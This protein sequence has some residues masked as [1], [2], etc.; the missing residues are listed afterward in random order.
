MDDRSERLCRGKLKREHVHVHL[1]GRREFYSRFGRG[2]VS[3]P[4]AVGETISRF[5]HSIRSLASTVAVL[6]IATNK[7]TTDTV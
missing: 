2:S 3:W 6:P 7:T 4:V 1:P 5:R